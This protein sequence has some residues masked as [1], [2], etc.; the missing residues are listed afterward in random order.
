MTISKTKIS[1]INYKY[2][3]QVDKFKSEYIFEINSEHIPTNQKSTITNVNF[4]ISEL[5]EPV[6]NIQPEESLD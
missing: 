6:L 3:I 4:L 1:G 5:I 2:Q